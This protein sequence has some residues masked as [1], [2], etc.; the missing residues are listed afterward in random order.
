MTDPTLL[1]RLEEWAF[2]DGD[3]TDAVSRDY[4]EGFRD[5][6][7]VVLGFIQAWTVQGST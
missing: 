5:A 3:F 4:I 1:D 2:T 6:Q 7:S